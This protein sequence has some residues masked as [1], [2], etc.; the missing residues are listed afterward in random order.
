VSILVPIALFGWIPALLLIFA[1][2]PPRRAVIVAFLLAWLFLPVARYPIAGLPDYTKMSATCAGVLLATALFDPGRF[3]AFRPHWFDVPMAIWCAVPLATSLSNGLGAYDGLSSAL[4]HLVTWGFPYF[5]GRLYFSDLASLRE[6]TIG[7]FVGGLLYVPLCLFE[8]RMSPQLHTMV[9]GFHPSWG[10]SLRFGGWRPVVFMQDGL[11]VG[12]WMAMTSLVGAWLWA[13]RV[14]KPALGMPPALLVLLLLL[15]TILCKSVGALVL[16][17]VGLSTLFATRKLRTSLIVLLVT[18]APVAYMLAR[19]VGG[20]SGQQLIS[21]AELVSSDRA[22]SLA[23]RLSN[24]D[25]LGGRAMLRPF[26]GW[27]GWGRGFDFD[28]ETQRYG[29]IPDGMWIIALSVNGAVGLAALTAVQLLPPL[30]VLRRYRARSWG[31]PLVAAPA[32]MAVILALYAT[33]NLFNAMINPIYMLIA[34]GLTSLFLARV[35]QSA[36]RS[37]PAAL[38]PLGRVVAPSQP[39]VFPDRG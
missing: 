3:L 10:N 29:G 2:L 20:W 7:I 11:M 13:C 15:T 5:I 12:T 6:L 18:A 8:I 39:P 33:D 4:T 9:Y 26:V 36:F 24:E 31:T 1:L 27:G 19:T 16:L 23:T 14:L 28:P 17:A 34:G 37:T 22:S 38:S 21:V 35:P 30:L 25:L 32:A